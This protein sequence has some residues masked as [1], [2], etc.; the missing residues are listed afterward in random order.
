MKEETKAQIA[1]Y[2]ART[3]VNQIRKKWMEEYPDNIDQSCY[4]L[5]INLLDALMTAVRLSAGVE[6]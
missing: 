2:N 5:V 3:G 1:A 6:E 4:A